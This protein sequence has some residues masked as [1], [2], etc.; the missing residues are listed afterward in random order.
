MDFLVKKKLN[1]E[2]TL[3][4][5]FQIALGL[6]FL[7]SMHITH[8][9]IKPENILMKNNILKIADFGFAS[10]SSKLTTA[11]GTAPYMSPELFQ[12]GEEAYTHKVDVWALNTCLYKLL[13]G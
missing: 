12:D 1:E 6:N 4:I 10:N 7:H 8:R 13:T 9:D 11:L 5:I 2:Q 3:E